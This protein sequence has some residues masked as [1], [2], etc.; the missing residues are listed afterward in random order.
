MSNPNE[1]GASHTP[2][3]DEIRTP[4][5]D[6]GRRQIVVN[7]CGRPLEVVSYT[8]RSVSQNPDPLGLGACVKLSDA[9]NSVAITGSSVPWTNPCPG[10]WFILKATGGTA[11]ILG[12]GPAPI[13]KPVT[14]PTATTTV[15]S[16]FSLIVNEGES[17]GPIRIGDR[18]LAVIGAA[19]AGTLTFLQITPEANPL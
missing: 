13:N 12:S 4:A 6:S 9:T 16:G 8:G 11:Y 7:D 10:G 17:F 14:A 15:T 1:K 3:D 19:A 2:K 5:V 18:K